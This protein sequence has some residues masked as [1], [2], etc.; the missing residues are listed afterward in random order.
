M[1]ALGLIDGRIVDLK[2]NVIAM[3]DRGYQFGDGV[4]EY[5]KVY[6]GKCFSLKPHID[7]LFRSLGELRIPATYTAAELTKF[8]ELLIA[9][10]GIESGGIYLQ[11]T[12]GWA[13]RAHHFPD[14]VLPCLTMTI[15][16]STMNPAQWETGIGIVLTPDERW[17]RCDIKSLN[18]LG[19]VMAK[20][21]AKEAGCY[22]AVQVRDNIVT[23]GTSSNFFLVIDGAL[24][25]YPV[26]NLILKGVTRTRVIEEIVPK[27]KLTVNEKM[28]GPDMIARADEAFL[29]GT[30]TEIMPIITVD[31][32]TVGQGKPGQVTRKIMESYNELI[33]NEC[34]GR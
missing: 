26:N 9:E 20:Q 2:E 3:E 12:R 23:E 17:L 6:Q 5:A 31:G 21:K 16:P 28:I 34:G 24:W 13:P 33:Q 27:L 19:N 18:L 10:S 7:R 15:R 25:T 1:R 11:I 30:T 32:K 8:H 22:E 4:Y 14:T 29:S